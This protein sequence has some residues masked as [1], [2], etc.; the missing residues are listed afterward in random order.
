MKVMSKVSVVVGLLL[1]LVGLVGAIW[2]GWLSYR[3]WLALDA[4]RSADVQSAGLPLLIGAAG[5]LVGGFFTGLGLGR[6]RKELAQTLPP[7]DS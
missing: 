7:A 6:P 1:V 3:Q 5:L 4:L 2:A